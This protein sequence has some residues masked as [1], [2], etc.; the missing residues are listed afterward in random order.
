MTD[1]TEITFDISF[2][3]SWLGKITFSMETECHNFTQAHAG[4]LKGWGGGCCCL[5]EKE[6]EESSSRKKVG[7]GCCK[8]YGQLLLQEELGRL[9]RRSRHALHFVSSMSQS[10]LRKAKDPL[11]FEEARDKM[12]IIICHFLLRM[13]LL[14]GPFPFLVLG[15]IISHLLAHTDTRV[16]QPVDH[17]SEMVL[18]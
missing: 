2:Q 16:P 8:K 10:H 18:D 5:E 11:G 4:M 12:W 15:I 3:Q 14:N 6:E 13:R 1:C 9:K 17:L 7:R